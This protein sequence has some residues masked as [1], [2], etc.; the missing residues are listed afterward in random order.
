MYYCT[1]LIEF[2]LYGALIIL[3]LLN[4]LADADPILADPATLA[5]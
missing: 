3:I 5:R 4:C 1:K 2:D